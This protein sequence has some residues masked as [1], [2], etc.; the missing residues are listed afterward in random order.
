MKLNSETKVV[1]VI[2]AVCIVL[3]GLFAWLAPKGAEVGGIKDQTILVRA[4]SHMTGQVGAK[5]TVVEFG[6]YQCPACANVEP[7]L[8]QLVDT[9]KT[10]P[11]F[12]FVYRN[13]P[14][15]QHANA[16][17]SAEAAEVAGTQGQYWE[18]HELL[19]KNQKDWAEV[20]QPIDIFVGYAKTLGLDTVKFRTD[21]E[22]GKFASFI[23][24]DKND[25]DTVG[26]AY[27]PTVFLNG[28]EVTD[29]NTLKAK[30]DEALAK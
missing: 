18:M 7:F 2:V 10:N 5:V 9:Y 12:N 8:K 27:T 21:V 3:F 26:I 17:I 20:A 13:F 24:S 1:I 29:L 23:N 22:A 28:V 4:D 15:P 6:D 11:D 14:L 25:G 30:I 19:Y 16:N